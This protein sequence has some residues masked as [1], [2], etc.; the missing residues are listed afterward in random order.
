MKRWIEL[1]CGAAG[2]GMALVAACFLLAV[3]VSHAFTLHR[4]RL[5]S[6]AA[7]CADGVDLRI[8]TREIL[9]CGMSG[10]ILER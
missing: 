6:Q 5:G 3:V 7:Q 1:C 10:S 9:T 2:H 8:V 4:S